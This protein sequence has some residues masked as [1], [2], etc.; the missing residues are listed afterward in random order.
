MLEHLYF[1]GHFAHFVLEGM[2]FGF[3]KLA[4]KKIIPPWIGGI[5]ALLIFSGITSLVDIA[6]SSP[7]QEELTVFFQPNSAS[8]KAHE[9]LHK[10]K[11]M[12]LGQKSLKVS[13]VCPARC[14]GGLGK[15]VP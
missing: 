4:T 10:L 7:L 8:R 5:C 6:F 13:Q 1:S 11:D 2:S 15:T 14:D 9:Y 12:C 3:L